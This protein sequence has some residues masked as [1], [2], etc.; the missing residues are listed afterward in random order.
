MKTNYFDNEENKRKLKKVLK[1]W[2]GTPFRH[3]T[4]VKKRGV[5]CCLFVLNVFDELGVVESAP[6][7]PF[8]GEDW[9]L[10]TKEEKIISYINEI[11]LKKGL[12]LDTIESDFLDGDILCF[13]I[14][15]VPINHL[16]IWFEGCLWQ[17]IRGREIEPMEFEPFFR[18]K[19]Q[20]GY[21]IVWR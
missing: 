14:R 2:E 8:Y 13:R 6:E 20:F 11:K 12:L 4:A 3:R 17:A 5:D 10:H 9:F 16:A 18:S 7:Y 1:S 15:S 21:R 19:F